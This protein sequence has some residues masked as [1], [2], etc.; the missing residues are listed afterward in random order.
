MMELIPQLSEIWKSKND[1]VIKSA[2]EISQMLDLTHPTFLETKFFQLKFLIT[3]LMNY[4]EDLIQKKADLAKLPNF[5]R[6]TT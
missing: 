5:L 6:R 4:Q 2:E 3:H 1:D